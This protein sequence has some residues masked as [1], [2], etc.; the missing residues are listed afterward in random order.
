MNLRLGHLQHGLPDIL[1]FLGKMLLQPRLLMLA[2]GLDEVVHSPL[3]L[4]NQLLQILMHAGKAGIGQRL[5]QPVNRRFADPGFF[6]DALCRL[7]GGFMKMAL[8]IMRHFFLSGAQG[9]KMVPDSFLNS[10]Q[11]AS[12]LTVRL[13]SGHWRV[14]GKREPREYWISP[15]RRPIPQCPGDRKD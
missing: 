8:D 14:P 2:C 1:R 11:F 7:Q 13:Y 4:N 9:F 10:Q 12:L 6:G 15:A 5:S 3:I